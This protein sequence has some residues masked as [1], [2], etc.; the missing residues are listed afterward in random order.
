M[1]LQD[2][3]EKLGEK[4]EN[5]DAKTLE[6]L[7]ENTEILEIISESKKFIIDYTIKK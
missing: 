2:F 5:W 3:E 7:T 1:L 6:A 4:V